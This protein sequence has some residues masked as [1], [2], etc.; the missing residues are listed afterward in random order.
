MRALIY[1]QPWKMPLEDVPEPTLEPDQVI[2]QVSAVGVCGSDVHGF[3][4]ST[5]RR[6]PGII[7]GHEFCGT[8]LEIGADLSGWTLGERVVVNPLIACLGCRACLAG[9][10]HGCANR[11]GIGWSVH[12]AYAERVAVPVRNLRRLPDT[13][14]DLEGALVE[15]LAVALRAVNRTPFELG[16]TVAVVGAVGLET[17]RGGHGDRQ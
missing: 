2:V 6:Q 4:G 11:R 15:P 13:V 3:T 5:G 9:N 14:S 12:G 7:M 8:L 10:T 17:Q 16:A 1:R